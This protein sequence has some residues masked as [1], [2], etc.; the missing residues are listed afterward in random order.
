MDMNPLLKMEMDSDGIGHCVHEG[1]EQPARHREEMASIA[2][3]PG[4]PI[5]ICADCKA[6]METLFQKFLGR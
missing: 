5:D 2:G 1:E 3:K 6:R 4:T